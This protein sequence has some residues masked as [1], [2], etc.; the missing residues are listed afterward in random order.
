MWPYVFTIFWYD[1]VYFLKSGTK[2]HGVTFRQ[3][4]VYWGIRMSF[5]TVMQMTATHHQSAP[6]H[7]YDYFRQ[8][9]RQMHSLLSLAHVDRMTSIYI[10]GTYHQFVLLSQAATR[11]L[12]TQRTSFLQQA[13][14]F[15]PLWRSQHK[16]PCLQV[17]S[18]VIH[19]WES[20]MV[21]WLKPS[22]TVGFKY[23]S[24]DQI[25][26]QSCLVGY[27]QSF[28]QTSGHCRKLSHDRFLLHSF[29]SNANLSSRHSM[30]MPWATNSVVKKNR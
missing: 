9:S 29:Q 11:S 4:V 13:T 26:R 7:S 10:E 18:P 5:I 6:A 24:R 22:F 23:R 15:L 19:T 25:S 2:L 12:N 16:T 28:V 17:S 20:P 1:A 14:R 27:F 21:E 30:L 3:T 8:A